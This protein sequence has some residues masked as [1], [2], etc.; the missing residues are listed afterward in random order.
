MIPQPPNKLSDFQ[1]QVMRTLIDEDDVIQ[2]LVQMRLD[3]ETEK[4]YAE[5][6]LDTMCEKIRSLQELI[7]FL[8]KT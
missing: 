8:S 6:N 4:Y 2:R 7:N 5:K 3:I 1:K